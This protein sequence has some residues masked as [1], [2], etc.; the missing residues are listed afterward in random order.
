MAIATAT[1]WKPGMDLLHVLPSEGESML[2]VSLRA[3]WLKL[4]RSGQP[5]LLP[6]AVRAVDRLRAVF[7]DQDKLTPGFII[8][9]REGMRL[10]QAEFGHKLGVS[11]MTVSRWE[12]GKMRPGHRTARAIRKLQVHARSSGVKIDAQKRTSRQLN[13]AHRLAYAK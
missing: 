4:D 12:R 10:T 6:P 7:T 2:V 9:L 8:S 3:D 13:S 1:S 5:L 11:K